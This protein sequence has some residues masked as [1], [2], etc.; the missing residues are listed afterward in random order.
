MKDERLPNDCYF[1]VP[2]FRI[3]PLPRPQ[4][5][6][7]PIIDRPVIISTDRLGRPQELVTS[8]ELPRPTV[9]PFCA[10]NER[11]TTE[12]TYVDPQQGPWRVRVVGNTFPAVRG[13]SDPLPETA[14]LFHSV[15][16]AGIHEVVIACPQHETSLSRLPADHLADFLRALCARMSSLLRDRPELYPLIFNN[17]KAA[18]G[19]SMAHAHAQL[20]ALAVVP[21][22]VQRELDSA[23]R[24]RKLKDA[25]IFCDM[26]EH[27][28]RDGA[29]LVLQSP[30]FIV[31]A[32]FASRFPCELWLLPRHHAC[33][34]DKLSGIE[35]TELGEVFHTV[36]NKLDRGL[37]DPPY[38]FVIHTAPRSAPEADAFHWHIEFLPR[39]T[40][41]AGFEFG[42]GI[43]INPVPPEQAAEYLRGIRV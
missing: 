12:P 36:L 37:L 17:H 40:G 39:L 8:S 41:I 7:D 28:Q 25:C 20:L 33:H 18:A 4:L 10:G 27:E 38:N 3:A 42:T 15:A 43:H 32:P 26:I 23:S 5:R 1:H 31:L 24:H 35:L 29:R 6:R 14:G 11:L 9:C 13:A 22:L 34:F 19:A 16:A 30:R 2:R 21:E